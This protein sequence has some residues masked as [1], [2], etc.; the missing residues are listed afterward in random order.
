MIGPETGKQVTRNRSKERLTV[1]R[2]A[3]GM[4]ARASLQ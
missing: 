4:G 1:C 2:V 3:V